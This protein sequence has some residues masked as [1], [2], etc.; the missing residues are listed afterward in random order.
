MDYEECSNYAQVFAS[1]FKS[2]LTKAYLL[3][4][5]LELINI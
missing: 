4:F 5:L 1:Y 3:K 2:L